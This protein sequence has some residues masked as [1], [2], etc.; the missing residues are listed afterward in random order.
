MCAWSA[1]WAGELMYLMS[2]EQD[3]N[4]F[5]GLQGT[6]GDQRR[7]RSHVDEV[8][9]RLAHRG[10]VGDLLA[11]EQDFGLAQV[12]G[13]Q[14]CQRKHVL[15]HR[16]HRA[17]RQQQI[18]AGRDH[19]GIDDQIGNRPLARALRHRVDDLRAREH[20]GFRGGDGKIVHHRVDLRRD[21]SRFEIHHRPHANRVLRG[22]RGYR[23]GAKYAERG[24]SLEVGL[25][26]G[27]TGRVR[28]RDCEHNFKHSGIRRIWRIAPTRF[29]STRPE[30]R[31][32]PM[33]EMS[34]A[35]G[36]PETLMPSPRH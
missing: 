4:R 3:V 6:S 1:A 8:A 30:A 7:T 20:S 32:V 28:A 14:H 35:W 31:V 34:A 5:G 17:G 19:H 12:R 15:A 9:R 13:H 36:K 23:A 33:R 16:G 22:K 10:R 11:P 24:E 25:N 26:P 2:V 21:K 29:D 27:A 18:A